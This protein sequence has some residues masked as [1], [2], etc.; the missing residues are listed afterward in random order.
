LRIEEAGRAEGGCWIGEI[1]GDGR[2][3]G[4]PEVGVASTSG[5][6]PRVIRIA[7]LSS[8]LKRRTSV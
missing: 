2:C 1:E 6:I 8:E 3:M 5:E 4:D 7:V